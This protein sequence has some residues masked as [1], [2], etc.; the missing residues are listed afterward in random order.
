M[1]GE[2]IQIDPKILS[3]IKGSFAE[4]GL[5]RPFVQ[6]IFLLELHVAGTSHQELGEIEE[7]LEATDVLIFKREPKNNNDTLAIAVYEENGNQLGYIPREKNEVLARLMDAG[8]LVF[9]KL[10]K[11]KWHN[12]WLKLDIKVFMRDS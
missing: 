2:I 4:S 8:K 10:I 9:G 1:P 11:K 5:P 12:N 7:K 6:E 3:I